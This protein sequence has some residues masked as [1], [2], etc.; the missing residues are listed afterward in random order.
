MADILDLTEGDEERA[1]KVAARQAA[2]RAESKTARATRSRPSV[3]QRAETE[4][5]ERTVHVFQRIA[6][7]LAA[8]DD[9]ELATAISEDS[10]AMATGLVSLTRQVKWLRGPLLFF[11]SLAEPLLAFGRVGRILL[12]RAGEWRYRRAE[13]RAGEPQQQY[14]GPY[15][16][17]SV[18]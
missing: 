10:E 15:E 2:G 9:E 3:A 12:R 14:E 7:T 8:R 4:L 16:A 17:T 1:E 11:L 18:L 13:E 5:R 6:D